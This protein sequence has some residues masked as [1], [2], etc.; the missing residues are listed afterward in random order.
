MESIWE[1]LLHFKEGL[2]V[3][4][5]LDFRVGCRQCKCSACEFATEDPTTF[6]AAIGSAD[7]VE[8]DILDPLLRGLYQDIQLHKENGSKALP[9]FPL[10]RDFE[11]FLA[12]NTNSSHLPLCFGLDLLLQSFGKGGQIDACPSGDE[13]PVTER[14]SSSIVKNARKARL[15]ALKLSFGFIT[16]L[17]TTLDG[18]NMPCIC[19]KAN[20]TSVISTVC[21]WHN[22]LNRFTRTKRFDLLYHSPWI[23]GWHAMT[24]LA[25]TSMCGSKLWHYGYFVGTVMHIYNALAL[26]GLLRPTQLPLLESICETYTEALFMGSRSTHNVLSCWRRWGGA[27]VS[28]TSYHKRAN[29]SNGHRRW[30]LCS[31]PDSSHGSANPKRSYHPSRVSLFSALVDIDC[32]I[33]SDL[34]VVARHHTTG[35][36]STQS[37]D[38]KD[39]DMSFAEKLELVQAAVLREF[40]NSV[41]PLARINHVAVYHACM[42]FMRALSDAHHDERIDYICKCPAEACLQACDTYLK[43]CMLASGPKPKLLGCRICDS[44]VDLLLAE[45]EGKKVD[46]FLWDVSLPV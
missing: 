3:R 22:A 31:V 45:F 20:G 15:H 2:P 4:K 5:D 12:G 8:H 14:S 43:R 19:F 1:T 10:L 39:Q 36:T 11:T 13:G 25:R 23:S 18:P 32:R 41:L 34:V 33:D 28:Q 30:D 17:K 44:C 38:K 29:V 26:S 35:K 40:D 37:L 24:N 42:R 7:L 21:E 27:R 16:S 6:L 9:Y 46:E